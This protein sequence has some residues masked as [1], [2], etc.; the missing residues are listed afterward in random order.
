MLEFKIEP[1]YKEFP[2]LYSGDMSAP[3]AEQL[4]NV[5]QFELSR[6]C[7]HNACTYCDLF[8]GEKNEINEDYNKHVR[9]VLEELESARKLQGKERIFIGN[10]DALSVPT[11][12]LR[13][14]IDTSIEL[15]SDYTGKLP[16]RVAMYA[17]VKNVLSK[18]V[19][20]LKE[21]YCGG[22][23]Y[24]GCS[25][26]RFEKRIGLELVY[27]GLE[28]GDDELLRF[29][30]KGCT[31]EEELEAVR[32]LRKAGTY[33]SQIRVSAFVM[34]G[35]GGRRFF[36]Q[37]IDGTV[38][39]LNKLEPSF[40]NLMTI[41]PHQDSV[42]ARRMKTEFLKGE[43]RPLTPA[44]V[45]EQIARIIEGINFETTVGCFDNSTYLGVDTNPVK[46][47]STK[48]IWHWDKTDLTQ[49]I[50][51]QAKALEEQRILDKDRMIHYLN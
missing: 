9:R 48:L 16:R 45:A 6:G 27:L 40:I 28:T 51:E 30:A 46:F 43:N 8:R 1:V 36:Q 25:V 49:K 21:L 19:D 11:E 42:Y 29:V 20:E 18:P 5:V 14:A 7:T 15:F 3:L 32:R 4:P 2:S 41:H 13:A 17:S 50:R 26:G 35:L 37:H 44:E 23:C 31:Q 39:V 38:Q 22:T 47:P 34:P 33:R 10:G 12:R 24:K